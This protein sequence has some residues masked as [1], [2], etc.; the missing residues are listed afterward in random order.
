[1][2]KTPVRRPRS[3]N[4]PA[5]RSKPPVKPGPAGK[6][7][8]EAKGAAGVVWQRRV[9]LW[10]VEALGLSI[11]GLS[12]IVVLLG[13][14]AERFGGTGLFSSLLPF[15]AGILA[16]MVLSAL[17]LLGWLKLRTWLHRK[18][19][20]L[21][22]V[23]AVSLAA[24]VAGWLARHDGF[25]PALARFRA[26]V[27]GRQ[28][29]RRVTLAHQVYAAYRRHDQEQLR[30]LVLRGQDYNGPIAA[31]AAAFA[32][33]AQLLQGVAAVESSFL[34]RASKDGGRGLFQITRV[35]EEARSAAAK[36]LGVDRLSLGDA[37]HN[38]FVAAAT[39]HYYLEQMRGDLFLGLL[40]YNIGPANGGL[41]FIMQQYGASD[42]VTIQPYLQKLPRDYPI[43]VL[44]Y[45][46]AFRIYRKN[47]KLLPYEAANNAS[48]IQGLGIPGLRSEL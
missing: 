41:R 3:S 45:A 32:V 11:I 2:S 31:A 13:Y 6:R 44:A 27:G 48:T 35:P 39:L 9:V 34:P 47:G 46:L 7:S 5:T 25:T 16:L 29:A 10:T 15:A 28:E 8:K 26:L 24:V 38:A 30:L 21:P 43:R 33:D 36:H 42:F 18:A 22:A 4:S 37:R 12:G 20:L 19:V 14:S 1:M 23:L 40:A 17:V